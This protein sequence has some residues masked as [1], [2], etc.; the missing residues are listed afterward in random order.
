M[1]PGDL[2]GRSLVNSQPQR[3]AAD[4]KSAVHGCA[5]ALTFADSFGPRHAVAL[6]RRVASSM[7]CAV[8]PSGSVFA[9]RAFRS[10]GGRRCANCGARGLLADRPQRPGS[11]ISAE[12][13][14]KLSGTDCFPSV[15]SAPA[16]G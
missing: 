8:M 10:P 2:P 7:I 6:S 16:S 3:T 14:R 13:C 15:R 12:D 9:P 5:F 1:S 4:F 11:S